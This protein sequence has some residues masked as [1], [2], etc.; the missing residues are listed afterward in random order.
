MLLLHPQPEAHCLP[1][2]AEYATTPSAMRGRKSACAIAISQTDTAATLTA[3]RTGATTCRPGQPWA[4]P[5]QALLLARTPGMTPI[6]LQALRY[7]EGHDSRLG[8]FLV[9]C[10]ARNEAF[11]IALHW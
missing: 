2:V 8:R 6:R 3:R 7:E 4:A 10:A 11:A 9:S 5:Y 1:T